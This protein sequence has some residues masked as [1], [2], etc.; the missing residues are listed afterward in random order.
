MLGVSDGQ[1]R[2]LASQVWP[3]LIPCWVF[4]AVVLSSELEEW[5]GESI[6]QNWIHQ[7]TVQIGA[8]KYTSI[9]CR[10]RSCSS[11]S[12]G[13]SNDCNVLEIK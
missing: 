7:P 4:P 5:L 6:G 11:S 3:E 2:L 9:G 8:A 10:H 12:N 1:L 13:V